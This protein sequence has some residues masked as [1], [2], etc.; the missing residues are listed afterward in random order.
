MQAAQS[1]QGSDMNEH[2][3]D[4]R[5]HSASP[6]CFGL[7]SL[8]NG[9][10]TMLKLL[11]QY[12]LCHLL[13]YMHTSVHDHTPRSNPN[14]VSQKSSHAKCSARCVM[15]TPQRAAHRPCCGT[16]ATSSHQLSSASFI[17]LPCIPTSPSA[18][19]RAFCRSR[20]Q[21]KSIHSPDLDATTAKDGL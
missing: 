2:D 12:V 17:N 21:S 15:Y 3:L 7:R 8:T 6:W 13:A 19:K 1:T 10:G 14:A 18:R 16:L 9:T 20:C 5:L 4:H 11:W